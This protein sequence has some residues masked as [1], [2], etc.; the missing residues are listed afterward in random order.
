VWR[1]RLSVLGALG[2]TDL[3]D[4]LGQLGLDVVVIEGDL[5]VG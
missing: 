2:T 3:V 4:G 1:S 5:R